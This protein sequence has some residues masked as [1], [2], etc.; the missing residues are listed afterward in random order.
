MYGRTPSQYSQHPPP[1]QPY[2]HQRPQSN[3]GAPP[4]PPA[5]FSPQG[6]PPS[7]YHTRPQ[8]PPPQHQYQQGGKYGPAAQGGRGGGQL[9]QLKAWLMNMF[10]VDRSGTI[11][12]S[13]FAGLWRYIKDWQGIFRQFDRDQSG[14][15][16]GNEFSVALSQFGYQLSPNLVNLLIKKYSP[17]QGNPGAAPAGVNFDRFV[18]CCVTVKQLSEGF[19]GHDQDRDGWVQ[20]SYE[21]FMQLVLSAP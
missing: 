12:F 14:T 16:D 15:M 1:Q 2:Q 17:L 4:L 13:E 11:G 19:K 20:I 10:D 9:D 7:P 8:P 6:P 5:P 21:Q 18:R 3:Y